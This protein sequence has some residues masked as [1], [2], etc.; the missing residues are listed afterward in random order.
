VAPHHQLIAPTACGGWWSGAPDE[1]G[2]PHTVMR[3]GAPNGT[4]LGRFDGADY[5]LEFLPARRPVEHQMSI[6]AP[7]E[8]AATAADTTEFTANIFAGSERSVV[9]FRLDGEEDWRPM[10][11]APGADPYLS[12]LNELFEAEL[13]PR[14]W[15][16]PRAREGTAHIWRA[17]LPA[18]MGAGLRVIEVRERDM[19]GQAHFGRRIIRIR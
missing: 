11:R 7:E 3:D 2:L 10:E 12:K 18:E 16:S 9:E 5:R 8:V 6:W 19:F 1:Y 14:D 17:S 15:G 4:T 13:I